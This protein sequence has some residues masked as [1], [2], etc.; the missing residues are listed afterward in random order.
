LPFNIYPVK[1]CA[2]NFIEEVRCNRISEDLDKS[3][4]ENGKQSKSI[5]DLVS[6]RLHTIVVLTL[7]VLLSICS[8]LVDD[9]RIIFGIVGAFSEAIINF[10]LPGIFLMMTEYKL[11]ERNVPL[12]VLGFAIAAFGIIYFMMSNYYTFMKIINM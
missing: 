12:I 9:L 1:V 11:K 10:I 6:Y 7:L 4:K 2:L 3:L 5:E 8:L